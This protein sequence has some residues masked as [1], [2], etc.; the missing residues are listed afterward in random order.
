[1]FWNNLKKSQVIP[2]FP[3]IYIYI[4]IPMVTQNQSFI[5]MGAKNLTLE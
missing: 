3:Y 2:I 5:G 4:Y 1:M